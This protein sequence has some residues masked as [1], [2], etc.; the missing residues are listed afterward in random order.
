MAPPHAVDPDSDQDG[1]RGS[2]GSTSSSVSY[3]AMPP[4]WN[5]T[6]SPHPEDISERLRNLTVTDLRVGFTRLS[7]AGEPISTV[8]RNM[9]H[10][11]F[12]L[13][14]DYVTR[15]CTYDSVTIRPIPSHR[16]LGT[17]REANVWFIP[18]NA[19]WR[20]QFNRMCELRFSNSTTINNILDT[21]MDGAFHRFS[22]DVNDEADIYG[23]RDWVYVFFAYCSLS[24]LVRP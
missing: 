8:H 18:T 20:P 6:T 4:Q 3:T 13:Q 14:E 10:I 12:S 24:N 5:L 17:W 9:V 2:A 16:Y 15:S 11:Y 21:M 19:F 22:F 23:S 7:F 1:D